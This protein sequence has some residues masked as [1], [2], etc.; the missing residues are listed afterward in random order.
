MADSGS[1]TPAKAEQTCNA[2]IHM[3]QDLPGLATLP[4]LPVRGLQTPMLQVSF[5]LE[6]SV[7]LLMM[8]VPRTHISVEHLPVNGILQEA[9]SG[10]GPFL[11]TPCFSS[12]KGFWH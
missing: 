4:Q 7:E 8:Q 12:Q 6:Q 1:R 2:G 9:P 3:L 5:K 10:L 11:Q